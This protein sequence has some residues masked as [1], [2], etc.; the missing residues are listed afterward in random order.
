MFEKNYF[1]VPIL[2]ILY[3]TQTLSIDILK[4]NNFIKS[5]VLFWQTN[6]RQIL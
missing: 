2:N 3:K 6:V 4:I 5:T 1:Y